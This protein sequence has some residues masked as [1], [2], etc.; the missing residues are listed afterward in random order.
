MYVDEAGI[1]APAL[2]LRTRLVIIASCCDTSP[3]VFMEHKERMFF[4]QGA[5][6]RVNIGVPVLKLNPSARPQ[7]PKVE[8]RQPNTNAELRIDRR[9]AISIFGAGKDS[10]W[11]YSN[12]CRTR[13]GQ[14]RTLDDRYRA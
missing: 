5:V 1:F 9:M 2:E 6:G 12:A 7:V 13:R 3:S 10:G 14:S 4:C 11:A 8:V